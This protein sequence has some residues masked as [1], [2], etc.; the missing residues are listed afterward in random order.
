MAP[1]HSQEGAVTP[2]ETPRRGARAK[3]NSGSSV[4]SSRDSVANSQQESEDDMFAEELE[5]SLQENFRLDG[6]SE[7][8]VSSPHLKFSQK[9]LNYPGNAKEHRHLSLHL[10]NE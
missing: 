1:G 3:S 9:K 8:K 6:E 7:G 2:E 10:L 5:A 4:I